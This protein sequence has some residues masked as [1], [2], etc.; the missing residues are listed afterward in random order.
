M[1]PGRRRLFVHVRLARPGA[2]GTRARVNTRCPLGMHVFH[3]RMP[4]PTTAA[5]LTR[6]GGDVPLPVTHSSRLLER[7]RA[8]RSC[9]SSRWTQPERAAAGLTWS[10]AQCRV[11]FVWEWILRHRNSGITQILHRCYIWCC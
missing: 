1:P 4:A 7:P 6:S 3:H 2:W 10:S 11:E 9:A 5:I 8:V